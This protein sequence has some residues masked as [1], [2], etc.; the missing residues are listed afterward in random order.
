MTELRNPHGITDDVAKLPGLTE[1]ERAKL[2]AHL[3]SDIDAMVGVERRRWAR[4][5]VVTTGYPGD[6]TYPTEPVPDPDMLDAIADAWFALGYGGPMT[7]A[8]TRWFIA[9]ELDYPKG[10][11]DWDPGPLP[12]DEISWLPAVAEGTTETP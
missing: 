11:G 12:E 3:E 5:I 6:V 4:W 7:M 1:P 2:I 10:T 9:G 8:E